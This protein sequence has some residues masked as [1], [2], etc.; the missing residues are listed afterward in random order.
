MCNDIF[1]FSSGYIFYLLRNK[2]WIFYVEFELIRIQYSINVID[3][4]FTFT[5]TDFQM[6]KK[7]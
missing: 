7:P 6:I 1:L 3:L 4:F 2:S 5:S